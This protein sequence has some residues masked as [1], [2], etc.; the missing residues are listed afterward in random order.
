MLQ[1]IIE[2]VL[3]VVLV[4]TAGAI[5]FVTL[6]RF[7]PLGTRLQ[8]IENRRRILQLE[9]LT[10]PVHGV[11]DERDL[12]RLPDGETMCPQCYQEVMNG[13]LDSQ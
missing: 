2:A 5:V 12:V 1:I 13:K 11:H 9:S 7:T 6:R 10:C 3:F 4:G 8:Q